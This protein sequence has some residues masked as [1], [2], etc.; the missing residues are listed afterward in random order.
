MGTIGYPELIVIFLIVLLLFGGRKIPEIARGMG[1]AIREFRNARDDI[2]EAIEKEIEPVP[3]ADGKAAAPPPG[4]RGVA[5]T[6]S[7]EVGENGVGAAKPGH[8]DA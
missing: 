2:R 5:S 4:N 8:A 7:A 6:E 1:K 3:P